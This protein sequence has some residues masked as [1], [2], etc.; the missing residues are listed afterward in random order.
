MLS[1][2]DGSLTW[3]RAEVIIYM[4][5]MIKMTMVIITIDHDDGDVA[6]PQKNNLIKSLISQVDPHLPQIPGMQ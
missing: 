5:I 4:M 1:T 6:G 2:R 3:M